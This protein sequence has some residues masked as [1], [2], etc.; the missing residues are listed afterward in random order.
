MNKCFLHTHYKKI[1]LI[2]CEIRILSFIYLIFDINSY[3]YWRHDQPAFD[4][5]YDDPSN[6]IPD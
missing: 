3:A 1:M 4:P 5:C 2:L 6:N